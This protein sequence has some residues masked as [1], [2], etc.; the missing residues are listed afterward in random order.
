[1][2]EYSADKAQQIHNYNQ[3]AKGRPLKIG[4]D[5][6]YA[7]FLENKILKDKYSP[8]A[9]LAAAREKGFKTSVCRV[10]LYSYIERSISP[11]HK[12]RSMGEEP[13]EKAGIQHRQADRASKAAKYRDPAGLRK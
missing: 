11:A 8:A 3:T 6:A 2:V 10:T 1:M 12:Q 4:S 13:E 9:A 7:Q 5:H